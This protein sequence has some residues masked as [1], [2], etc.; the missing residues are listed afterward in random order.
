MRRGRTPHPHKEMNGR[1][2]AGTVSPDHDVRA[3][4]A[5]T[6]EFDLFAREVVRVFRRPMAFLVIHPDQ[7]ARIAR[8]R[9]SVER[10]NPS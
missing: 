7:T 3:S 6:I 1:G 2:G 4:R 8:R 5:A 9:V 10:A